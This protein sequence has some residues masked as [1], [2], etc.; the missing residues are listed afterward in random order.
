MLFAILVGQGV[1]D[2]KTHKFADLS[3]VKTAHSDIEQ[4]FVV[5]FLPWSIFVEENGLPRVHNDPDVFGGDICVLLSEANGPLQQL[6][7]D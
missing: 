1:E 5:L 6:F 3:S 7:S 4:A 2:V